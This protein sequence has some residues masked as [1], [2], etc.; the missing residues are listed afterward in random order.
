[1]HANIGEKAVTALLEVLEREKDI[2]EEERIRKESLTRLINLTVSTIYPTFNCKYEQIFALPMGL[3]FLPL[4]KFIHEQVGERI[5][6]VT[7][8][9]RYLD[10][11]FVFLRD[12][13]TL[14]HLR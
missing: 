7:V 9:I 13:F 5:R 8:L 12:V 3:P 2:L 10:D 4:R 11:Y 1:M 6:E 14:F